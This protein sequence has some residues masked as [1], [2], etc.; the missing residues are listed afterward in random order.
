MVSV[1][2]RITRR[3]YDGRMTL[4]QQQIEDFTT[5]AKQ[6]AEEHGE[7]LT[8]DQAFEMWRQ[9]DQAEVDLLRERLASYDAGEKGLPVDEVIAEVRQSIHRAKGT[10]ATR[11]ASTPLRSRTSTTTR[12]ASP[13]VRYQVPTTGWTRSKKR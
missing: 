2:T 6:L 3:W 4:L 7:H 5:F 10:S 8:L 13:R 11:S 9:V 12:T 1:L